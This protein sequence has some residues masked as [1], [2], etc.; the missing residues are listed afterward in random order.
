MIFSIFLSFNIMKWV[1]VCLKNHLIEVL[2]YSIYSVIVS[3]CDIQLQFISLQNIIGH[4][5]F[6]IDHFT[7]TYSIQVTSYHTHHVTACHN[8]HMTQNNLLM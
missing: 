3:L 6:M 7:I 5:H 8:S 1:L 4:I 2:Q